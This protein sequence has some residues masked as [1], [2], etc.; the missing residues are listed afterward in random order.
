MSPSS[1]NEKALA[2][3]PHGG[4]EDALQLLVVLGVGEDEEVEA[5]VG[6][7]QAAPV[8]SAPADLKER[9][10]LRPTPGRKEGGTCI[11]S[12]ITWLVPAEI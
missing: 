10:E 7:R 11:S 3:F 6:G 1:H 9:G 5:G 12:A 2:A 4:Q 8:G